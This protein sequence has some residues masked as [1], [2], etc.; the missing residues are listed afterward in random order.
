MCNPLKKKDVFLNI[1]LF[2]KKSTQ[3]S[4]EYSQYLFYQV[5]SHF[6]SI[7]FEFS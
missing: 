3:Y 7:E 5:V 1:C 4:Q 6:S 2:K